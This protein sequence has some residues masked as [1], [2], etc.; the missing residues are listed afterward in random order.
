MGGFGVEVEV[1]VEVGGTVSSV[2]LA[3]WGG[4]SWGGSLVVLGIA[5]KH[6]TFSYL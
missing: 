4:G 3:F 6:E 1:E 5:G 2:F